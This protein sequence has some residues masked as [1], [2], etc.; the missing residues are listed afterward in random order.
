L[1]GTTGVG[2][3]V[4]RRAANVLGAGVMSVM[5]LNPSRV[6]AA[7]VREGW[8]GEEGVGAVMRKRAVM[9]PTTALL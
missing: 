5:Q 2:T 7:E 3:S 1:K 9:K 4:S 6:E 8:F